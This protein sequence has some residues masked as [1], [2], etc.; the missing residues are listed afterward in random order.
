MLS[1]PPPQLSMAGSAVEV[2]IGA[3]AASA[4]A[5]ATRGRVSKKAEAFS[6]PMYD[7]KRG[8]EAS[9]PRSSTSCPR[10]GSGDP[11]PVTTLG[12]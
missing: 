10:G 6:R 7:Q 8:N 5:L 9:L 4:A 11:P 1:L 2:N 12:P 3:G